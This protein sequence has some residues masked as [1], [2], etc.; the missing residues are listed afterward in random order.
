MV[1]LLHHYILKI[2]TKSHRNLEIII[3]LMH[4]CANGKLHG[5][6]L[7]IEIAKRIRNCGQCQNAFI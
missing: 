7:N 5:E 6:T 1:F 3:L 2:L 4:I